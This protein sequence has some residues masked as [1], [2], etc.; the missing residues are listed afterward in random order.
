MAVCYFCGKT[1]VRGNRISHANNKSKRW[2]K[3][4][5][6]RIKVSDKGS[7]RSVAVCT[8]CIK[9]GKFVKVV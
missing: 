9:L 8:R 7:I 6:Q 3:P 1:K 4:N 5:L 2:S